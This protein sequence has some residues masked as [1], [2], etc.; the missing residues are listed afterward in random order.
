MI[1]QLDE[2]FWRGKRVFMTGHTGFKGSWLAYWLVG[3]GAKVTGYALPPST[4]PSL[5]NL[6][7]LDEFIDSVTGDICDLDFLRAQ[8]ER[9][10][11]EVVLHLAAQSIVSAGY[12]EPLKTFAT[13]VMGVVNI[14]EICRE[15]GGNLPVLVISS[16]KCYR[17]SGDGRAFRIDDPLGGHDPYSSSKAGTEIVVEGYGASYFSHEDGPMLASARAGNVVGGGDWSVNRLLPDGARAFSSGA[18]LV[19]RNPRS[20]RPWQHVLE[21]LFGY[22]LLVQAMTTDRSFARPW[23]FGP[24]Q[25]NNLAVRSVVERFAESWGGEATVEIGHA[26]QDWKEAATLHLDCTET[27]E[28]LAWQPVLDLE[29]T[30]E[31]TA[32]WYRETYADMSVSGV[33]ARTRAQ[34][35]D[36]VRIQSNCT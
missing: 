29:A 31:W 24:A 26:W 20:T 25:S 34:I 8:M 5:Y 22:L 28:K 16:D 1:G 21:P 36:Y 4:E 32:R 12:E 11:P 6:L 27:N 2:T 33:R 18:A 30:V 13:N 15:I 35:D 3:M 19:V 23:N 14:L 10:Q 7:N 17:N 9:A